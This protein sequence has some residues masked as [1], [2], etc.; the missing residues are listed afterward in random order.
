M[1]P[2]PFT[3]LAARLGTSFGPLVAVVLILLFL[4]WGVFLGFLRRPFL[5]AAAAFRRSRSPRGTHSCAEC[6]SALDPGEPEACPRCGG[7]WLGEDVLSRLLAKRKRPAPEWCSE[8][9]LDIGPCAKC[10]RSLEPGRLKG[11]DFAVYRCPAC[12][13]LWFGKTEWISVEL[14]LFS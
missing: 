7:R 11:E 6:G 5:R 12:R 4:F 3:W 9:G 13:G 2:D 14:R 1:T 8:P 10:G